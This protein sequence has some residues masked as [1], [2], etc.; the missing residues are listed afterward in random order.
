MLTVFSCHLANKM[1]TIERKTLTPMYLLLVFLPLAGSLQA[2]LLGRF[3]G[4]RG[5]AIVTTGCVASSFFLSCAA[6]YEVALSG[7]L[8]HISLSTWF[9]SELFDAAWGF[10]F[11]TLTVVML[12]VITSVSTLVHLYGVSYMSHDPHVPRFMSY[13][14]IFTFFMVMLVTSDNLFWMGGCWIGLIPVNQLLVYQ[15]AGF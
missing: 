11:D 13:L 8:C 1:K 7:S 14:S 12:V 15:A 4:S 5:A 6:F 2:G 3:L 10:Y 9:S